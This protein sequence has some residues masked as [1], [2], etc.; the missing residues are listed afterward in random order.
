MVK[1]LSHTHTL[2]F[3]I[4][5]SPSV[6]KL[7]VLLVLRQPVPAAAVLQRAAVLTAARLNTSDAESSRRYFFAPLQRAFLPPASAVEAGVA[8][9]ELAVD[10]DV[11]ASHLVY[12]VHGT[13]ENLAATLVPALPGLL[14]LFTASQACKARTLHAA[15]EI[16]CG[17][18]LSAEAATAAETLMTVLAQQW[19]PSQRHARPFD[20]APGGTGG[21]QR[22]AVDT[23][24]D[25]AGDAAE[26]LAGEVDAILRLCLS[27]QRQEL[28]AALLEE[29]VQ[30]AGSAGEGAVAAGSGFVRP[31]W[32]WTGLIGRFL[33]S[34]TRR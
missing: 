34:S 19:L 1:S 8:L 17:F 21:L 14:L 32:D 11:T 2:S 18:V 7:P 9:P 29:C 20:Y 13:A 26:R 27:S 31:D 30:R 24:R 12:V 15:K 16:L 25:A 10:Q 5:L 3:P 22:V 6:Q 4:H 28:S 33:F 23:A